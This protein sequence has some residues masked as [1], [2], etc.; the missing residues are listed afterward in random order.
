MSL[1]DDVAPSL[2]GH[3]LSGATVGQ[4]PECDLVAFALVLEIEDPGPASLVDRIAAIA[5]QFSFHGRSSIARTRP[6]TDRG[7]NIS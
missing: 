1:G 6:S 2:R 4:R 5:P 7:S 3:F